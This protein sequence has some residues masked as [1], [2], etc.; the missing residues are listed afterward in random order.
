MISK[1]FY[2]YYKPSSNAYTN[3]NDYMNEYIKKKLDDKIKDQLHNKKID[4]QYLSY[5]SYNIDNIINDKC[6]FLENNGYIVEQCEIRYLYC[7][8]IAKIKATKTF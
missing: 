4:I 8:F 6:K 3:I 2:K 1:P 5:T 7:E